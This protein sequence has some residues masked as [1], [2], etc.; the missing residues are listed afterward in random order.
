[1]GNCTK[2]RK[3]CVWNKIF[4]DLEQDTSKINNTNRVNKLTWII[5]LKK[6]PEEMQVNCICMWSK[7]YHG[8]WGSEVCSLQN[9]CHFFM[10][11]AAC[12]L[13]SQMKFYYWNVVILERSRN[14]WGSC[15]RV[16][17]QRSISLLCRL[18]SLG[19]DE[20][21]KFYAIFSKSLK[22][23]HQILKKTQVNALPVFTNRT[24][25]ENTK[26]QR[27]RNE[28][29]TSTTS[30]RYAIRCND[31]E[32]FTYLFGYERRAVMKVAVFRISNP[33]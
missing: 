9:L 19:C 4:R 21:I 16:D 2:S 11:I 5:K 27:Q 31:I 30:F 13:W 18:V 23:W 6:N 24:C 7:L 14:V 25:K 17:V 12:K 33:I 15:I 32:V 20:I 22:Y 8:W 26:T 28:Y 3:R 1:M 29:Y 10:N